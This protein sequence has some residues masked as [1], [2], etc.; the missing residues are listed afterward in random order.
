M[1]DD[2]CVL[3][4]KRRSGQ[5]SVGKLRN[6]CA[7]TVHWSRHDRATTV[8]RPHHDCA[9][10][11]AKTVQRLTNR[12]SPTYQE[13]AEPRRSRNFSTIGLNKL[14]PF[15]WRFKKCAKVQ[16]WFDNFLEGKNVYDIICIKD[17]H[18]A[19]SVGEKKHL[20][21]RLNRFSVRI[22]YDS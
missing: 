10:N 21:N 11:G 17:N 18:R 22:T 13:D 19:C 7:T 14:K 1:S 5:K 8:Q 2:C 20:K 4:A 12:L 15:V 3:R 9:L 16:E 6:G